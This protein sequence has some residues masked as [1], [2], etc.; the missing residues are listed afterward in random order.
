MEEV[1]IIVLSATVLIFAGFYIS[2][3]FKCDKQAKEIKSTNLCL[4]V[5]KED[6]KEIESMCYRNIT[7]L[8]KLIEDVS[9]FAEDF[10]S[11]HDRKICF[12]H[13]GNE[14]VIYY[15]A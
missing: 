10:N 12:Y 1:L 14:W 8:N 9:N 13:D 3:Y 6:N 15:D 4:S 5:L 7:T 2:L 11:W